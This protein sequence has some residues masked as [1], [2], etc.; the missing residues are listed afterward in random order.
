MQAGCH[1]TRVVSRPNGAA[2]E[3][4]ASTDLQLCAYNLEQSGAMARP[5]G[6]A[7]ALAA[8]RSRV[9]ARAPKASC[10]HYGALSSA[11]A[12][13]SA[14]SWSPIRCRPMIGHSAVGTDWG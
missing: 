4:F 13:A 9:R 8:E 12:T 10:E 14:G 2:D 11:V 5:Y 3:P 6:L 7:I 1:A